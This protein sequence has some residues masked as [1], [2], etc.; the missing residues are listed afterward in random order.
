MAGIVREIGGRKRGR[1]GELRVHAAHVS[2]RLHGS[3]FR[4]SG[5]QVL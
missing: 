3:S 2:S 5:L 4:Q 1:F